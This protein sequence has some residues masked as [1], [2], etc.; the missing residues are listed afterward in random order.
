MLKNVSNIKQAR[1]DWCKATYKYDSIIVGPK[2][3]PEGD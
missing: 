2:S 3:S 1:L